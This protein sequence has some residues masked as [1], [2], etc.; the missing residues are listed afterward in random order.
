EGEFTTKDFRTWCGSVAA[1]HAFKETGPF[2][3]EKEAKKKIGE[4]L[5]KVSEQLGNSR[6]VCKKYYVHP[7]LLEMYE[8]GKIEKMIV[9]K[10]GSVNETSLSPVEKTLISILETL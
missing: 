10:N 4:V 6:T 5:D 7:S 1:L 8:N 9:K 2:E 3:N